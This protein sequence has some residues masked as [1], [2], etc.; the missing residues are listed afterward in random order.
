[1]P[2]VTA[3]VT[4]V[5]TALKAG[6]V[7]AP[8]LLVADK[9]ARVAAVEALISKIQN[10]G[11]SVFQSLGLVDAAVAALNDKKSPMNREAAASLIQLLASKGAGAQ[12]GPYV[13]A[14]AAQGVVPALLEAFADKTPAVRA[15]AVD[16]VLALIQNSS[17]W[18]TANLLPVLLV[19]IKTAGKWQVKTGCL[20]ALDELIKVSPVTVA[21]LTPEII[22]VLAEAI[23]DTKADVKKAARESL[24]KT[25]ALISNK[26]VL[27]CFVLML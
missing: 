11:P 26:Y 5:P 6:A 15:N 24:K 22:P 10:D 21:A 25:T 23:W 8:T 1:M 27:F 12:L 14:D 16:A 17:P 20:L 4:S 2:A 7:D 3:A 19:Q 9:A 18:A 13:L